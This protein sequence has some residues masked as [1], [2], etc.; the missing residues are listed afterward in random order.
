M[1][2]IKNSL[3]IQQHPSLSSFNVS[4]KNT[5]N[6]KENV[7]AFLKTWSS[8]SKHLPNFPKHVAHFYTKS[9][10]INS[11]KNYHFYLQAHSHLDSTQG[12]F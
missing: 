9:T 4:C 11:G 10:Y 8:L 6:R 1:F 2:C 5:N 7:Y 12:N 3:Q